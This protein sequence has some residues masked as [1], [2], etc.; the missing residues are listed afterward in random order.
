MTTEKTTNYYRDIRFWL[1]L[2]SLLVLGGLT[3]L[4]YPL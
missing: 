3:V 4:G 2:T 1:V